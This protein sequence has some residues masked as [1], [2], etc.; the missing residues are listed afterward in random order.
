MG[1]STKVQQAA[2][3]AEDTVDI[4]EAIAEHALTHAVNDDE[5]RR[6][7]SLVD[8]FY[9]R[10]VILVISSSAPISELYLGGHVAFEFERTVGRLLEMQSLA[11][12]DRAHREHLEL[13]PA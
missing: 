8:E 12:V 13:P 9:D 3:G 1:G 11:Y 2:R 4:N 10:D 5:A 6:F 7:V